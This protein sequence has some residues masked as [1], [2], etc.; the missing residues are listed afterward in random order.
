MV[1]Q[2]NN[3][4]NQKRNLSYAPVCDLCALARGTMA[5]GKVLYNLTWS[6]ARAPAPAASSAAA[7]FDA[8][9]FPS[10]RCAAPAAGCCCPPVASVTPSC[11]RLASTCRS[12]QAFMASTAHNTPYSAS[13]PKEGSAVVRSAR[14]GRAAAAAVAQGR[15]SGV[16]TSSHLTRRL[17][18]SKPMPG[19]PPRGRPHLA[20]QPAPG[21]LPCKQ[22]ATAAEGCPPPRAP[23]SPPGQPHAALPRLP[24]GP[25]TPGPPLQTAVHPRRPAPAVARPGPAAAWPRPSRPLAGRGF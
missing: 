16:S 19:S 21:R 18:A 3:A 6:R 14:E 17:P 22:T 2:H 24:L 10:C 9:H 23:G 4:S 1:Q 12:L 15:S 25:A 13:R 20:R 8:G 5:A 11:L 7:A